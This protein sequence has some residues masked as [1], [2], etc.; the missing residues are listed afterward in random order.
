MLENENLLGK[1][2]RDYRSTNLFRVAEDEIKDTLRQWNI[3][4]SN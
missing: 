3:Y 2:R 4:C 1:T